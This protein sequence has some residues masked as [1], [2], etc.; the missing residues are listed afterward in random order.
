MVRTRT[1]DPEDLYGT[2][3]DA[4]VTGGSEEEELLLLGDAP[5]DDIVGALGD[6]FAG[7]EERDDADE[8]GLDGA[9]RIGK[10]GKRLLSSSS[11]PYGGTTGGGR[12]WKNRRLGGL[13]GWRKA[14]PPPGPLADGRRGEV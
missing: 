1:A 9:S 10:L 7:G 11:M 12:G 13:L 5:H 2:V 6:S 4:A 8:E 3:G 14:R